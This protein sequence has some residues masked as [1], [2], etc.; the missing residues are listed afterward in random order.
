NSGQQEFPVSLRPQYGE[1]SYSKHIKA[2]PGCKFGQH[3]AHL[4]VY[5]T[6]PYDS[7][8]LRCQFTANFELRF[9]Q[10]YEHA[11]DFQKFEYNRDYQ[12]EGYKRCIDSSDLNGFGHK[13][14][15]QVTDVFS[16]EHNHPGVVPELE[17]KL[18][19]S[20]VNCVDPPR[21]K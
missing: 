18:A 6:V 15:G 10:C 3:S 19:V 12:L 2:E 8:T 9:Y 17:R 16:F 4:F 11:F 14:R 1:W 20:H 7:S 5:A 13:F 21:S